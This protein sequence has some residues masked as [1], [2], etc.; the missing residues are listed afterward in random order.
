MKKISDYDI[1]R[2]VGVP[3]NTMQDWKKRD[4]YRKT[5]YLLLKDFDKEELRVKIDEQKEQNNSPVS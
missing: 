2:I 3:I 4:D 1:N 5:L